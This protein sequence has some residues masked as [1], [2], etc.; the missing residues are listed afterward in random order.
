MR[1]AALVIVGVLAY[2]MLLAEIEHLD[3]I[4]QAQIEKQRYFI[5]HQ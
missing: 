1:R 2:L 3:N 5:S 4:T